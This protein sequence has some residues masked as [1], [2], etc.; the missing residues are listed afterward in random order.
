MNTIEA[1]RGRWRE[2]LPALGVPPVFLSG[3]HQPCLLCGGKDRFRF[4]DRHGEGDYFCNQCGAGKGLQ[5]AMKFKGWDFKQAADEVDKIIG[6]LP[7]AQP[8]VNGHLKATPQRRLNVIWSSAQRITSHDAAG[9]YLAGRGIPGKGVDMRALRVTVLPHVTGGVHPCMIA[10]VSDPTG[11]ARQ[12]YRTFLTADG[13]KA[14]VSPVRMF[15]P[16]KLPLG[17]AIRLG[18]LAGTMGIAEGIE[19]ALAAAMLHFMPVWATTSDT[20]LAQW[21]PPPEA[22]QITVFGDNDRNFAGQA[23]AYALAKRLAHAGR[24]VEVAIPPT[25]GFD[26]NDELVRKV[27]APTPLTYIG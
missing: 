2:I 24:D 16:G 27:G 1:A 20:M 25:K 5:L 7:P 22:K 13:H 18:G 12:I 3:K 23:A 15:M 10:C 8:V 26:W 6:N 9:R 17:G 14:N 21:Q 19:T 11:K 4:T